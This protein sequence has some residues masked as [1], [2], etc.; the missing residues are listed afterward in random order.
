MRLGV[1]RI[2]HLAPDAAAWLALRRARLPAR[3][4]RFHGA[5][6]P[7]PRRT[8]SVTQVERYLDC[9]F[10]FFASH[11]LDLDEEPEAAEIA[12]DPRQ[13]G[14]TVHAVFQSFF[15]AWDRSGRGAI[16]AAALPEARELFARIADE[17]LASLPASVRRIERHRLVGSA[18]APG[19]GERVFRLEAQR[20]AT[21]VER[22][23][24]LDL[25]GTFDFGGDPARLVAIKGIADRVDLLGDGTFRLIDYKTGR[26]PD[27]DRAIQLAVYAICAEQTLAGHR[28]RRWRVGEAAYVALADRRPW[29]TVVRGPDD[30]APL[31]EGRQR[32]LQALDGIAGGAFPPAPADRRLCAACGFAAVC[33]KDYVGDVA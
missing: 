25:R 3:D 9:P 28:G 23:L 16:T 26:A 20:P 32:F 30:R 29:V 4:E 24:E 2:E 7:P 13:R 22:F 21:V 31:E 19:F 12:L 1:D 18:A 17:T 10:R 6:G 27:P 15:A 14:T 8:R 33:R 11:V 5:A